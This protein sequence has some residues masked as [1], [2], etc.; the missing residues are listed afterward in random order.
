VKLFSA[1]LL[2]FAKQE[3][4]S[5]ASIEFILL[6]PLMMT[7]LMTSIELGIL[8][9]RQFFLDRG[10]DMAIRLVRTRGI[11]NDYDHADLKN[12][13]C[14]FARLPNCTNRL[15]IEMS[16]VP[17]RNFVSLPAGTDCTDLSEEIRPSRTFIRGR[18]HQMMLVR[19]CYKFDPVFPGAGLGFEMAQNA[20]GGGQVKM[21]SVAA[22]V[23]EP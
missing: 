10:L 15:K 1:N 14:D 6:I 5:L 7:L 17:I 13:I 18:Q 20:D 3:R 2:R 4:G 8:Q 23:Q 22:F 11:A 12:Q 19:A 21:V 16:P 9:Y